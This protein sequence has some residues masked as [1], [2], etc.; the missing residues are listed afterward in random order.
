[1]PNQERIRIADFV[2]GRIADLGDQLTRTEIARQLG[3]ERE[4][5]VWMFENGELNS[6]WIKYQRSQPRWGSIP[7]IS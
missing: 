5:L 7:A 2:H 1:M 6:C 4:H 3:Y